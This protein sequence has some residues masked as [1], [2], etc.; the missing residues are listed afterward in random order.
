LE[1]G[2]EYSPLAEAL[3]TYGTA[4]ARLGNYER[5]RE[6]LQRAIEIAHNAGI[7]DDAGLAALTMLEELSEHLPLQEIEIIYQ[8][9]DQW[10]ADT[11][12][13][14]TIRRLRQAARQIIDAEQVREKEREKEALPPSFIHA[15]A[16]ITKILS[17]AQRIATTTLSPVLI[18][19]ETGTGK[20]LLARLIHEW[21]GRT[22]E[23]VTV[24]CSWSTETLV[25]SQLF[26][27]FKGSLTDAVEN[28]P[29]AVRRAAGGTLFL[30]EITELS[31]SNQAKLLRLVESGEVQSIGATERHLGG[32][33]VKDSLFEAV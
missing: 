14:Q 26:G 1:H 2:D 32:H 10:L 30:D 4:L 27:H 22:G 13:P 23:F 17:N 7:Y 15:S 31:R 20:E 3:T 19:G 28:H 11:Q 18:T 21:S 8:R 24:N 9:A 6:T 33:Q 16:Q 12:H 29:G 25:E 5:A